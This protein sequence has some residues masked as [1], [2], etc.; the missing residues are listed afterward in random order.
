MKVVVLLLTMF[1]VK[2]TYSTK[3]LCD[4]CQCDLDGVTPFVDCSSLTLKEP[5]WNIPEIKFKTVDV[6]FEDNQITAIDRIIDK[7]PIERLS[8]RSNNV[9]VIGDNAFENLVYLSYLDLSHNQIETLSKGVFT[10][11]HRTSKGTPSPILGLDLSFN[12]IQTLN[13]ATFE[14]LVHL[15]EI[16]LSGNV[17][18]K[19]HDHGTT[20]ALGSLRSLKLLNLSKTSID[21]LPKHFF[22]GLASLES[23]DLSHNNMKAVPTELHNNGVKSLTK[24]NLDN[25]AIIDLK[26]H[27]FIG[28]TN[29]KS[30]SLN[31][32]EMMNNI[33]KA[34]LAGLRNLTKLTIEHNPMLNFIDPDA[35]AEFQFPMVLEELSLANN[36]LR[37]LPK[38]LLPELTSAGKTT[39]LKVFKVTGNRWECDCHNEWLINLLIEKFEDSASEAICDNPASLNG[40]NFIEAKAKGPLPCDNTETFDAYKRDFG[41]PHPER[42]MYGGLS[43]AV[44]LTIAIGSMFAI[45]GSLAFVMIL[46]RKQQRNLGRYN[47]L[48]DLKIRF[49]PR[50]SSQGIGNSQ[51]NLDNPVYRNNP[52]TAPI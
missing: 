42:K 23:L 46:N 27:S 48:G 22:Q 18:L 19:M 12:K 4:Q 44:L 15:E 52:T 40:L 38:L 3:S 37:Y 10:G 30:L 29:L 7:F 26:S 20:T 24:L 51:T 13:R 32:M 39:S 50:P 33:K 47:K 25:N 14:H 49:H 1:L 5:L 36:N 16:N 28:M 8:F 31:H 43:K 6:D 2:S 9:S 17:H 11:P 21:I 35:F 41:L 45:L 34:S